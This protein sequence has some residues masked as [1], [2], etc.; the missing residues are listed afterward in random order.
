MVHTQGLSP[1]SSNRLILSLVLQWDMVGEMIAGP[2]SWIVWL[3]LLI[4]SFWCYHEI[5]LIV[6]GGWCFFS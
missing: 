1:A 2:I 5:Y 6:R 3:N 4:S